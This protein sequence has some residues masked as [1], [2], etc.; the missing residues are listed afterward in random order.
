MSET[1]SIVE[2]KYK[3]GFVTDIET[4]QIDKG[5]NEDIIRKI[6]AIKD[7]PEWML[8]YRLK[9][10][11]HWLTL[12]EPK[13][14]DLN[15]PPIDY[16]ALR[17]Y[18]APKSMKKKQSLDEV[19]PELLKTFEKLGI[20]LS[21]QK[22]I[23]GGL[24]IEGCC[25]EDNRLDVRGAIHTAFLRVG[26][27]DDL[28]SAVLNLLESN[29]QLTEKVK[30]LEEELIELKYHPKSPFIQDVAEKW[31]EKFHRSHE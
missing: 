21:E 31:N 15:Y 4:N 1:K 29:K 16:Q 8:N 3:F 12:E 27:V 13:W 24:K 30:Q 11:Q 7:E 9:A 14:A 23:S 10:Y 2:S 6:S 17:Y 5:L 22:R 25:F 20:P 26:K 19:D 18:S 28:E